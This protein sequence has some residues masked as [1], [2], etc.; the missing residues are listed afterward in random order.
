[1]LARERTLD[2]AER[3][4]LVTVATPNST[5]YEIASAFLAAGFN[6]LCEKPL[7]TTLEDGADLVATA[8]SAGRILAVNYGYTG[9]PMVRQA[10]AMAQSGQLGRIRIVV[11]EFAHGSHADAADSSNPR[12]RWRYDPDQAGVSSVLADTGLHALHMACYVLGSDVTR[13]S[14]DFVSSVAG[15]DLED[16]ALV[17]IRF[18]GGEV[19]RLWASA[20]A[21]GQAHGAVPCGC[22]GNKAACVGLKSSR[23]NSIGLLWEGPRGL[24]SAVDAALC[25][26][27]ARASRITVGHAEGML[28]AF[29][30]IYA[31]LAEAIPDR[32]HRHGFGTFE[33]S[34]PD[35]RG[36]AAYPG[37]GLRSGA[38]SENR[39][40]MGRRG[41]GTSRSDHGRETACAGLT[42]PS[43]FGFALAT[44]CAPEARPHEV[45]EHIDCMTA[46][47]DGS[48]RRPPGAPPGRDVKRLG[49]GA[50]RCS[51]APKPSTNFSMSSAV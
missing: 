3:L 20:V 13:V 31:D 51:P 8:R 17:A 50:R 15:R 29:A 5:H 6:V 18:S 2:A 11:A 25:V 10:R 19:G 49:R 16:D 43:R 39:R 41:P 36:R 30:N 34:L 7:T 22:L 42:R 23:T 12:I 26:E 28:E 35:R 48:R 40:R 45:L 32:R 46:S 4:D 27:T 1:M 37:G 33:N 44:P 14:A 47:A 38:V 24:W 21:V 9:Y